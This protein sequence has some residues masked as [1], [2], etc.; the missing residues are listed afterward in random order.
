MERSEW[1]FL[2]PTPLRAATIPRA[3]STRRSS[4]RTWHSISGRSSDDL[5]R[6]SLLHK[7]TLRNQL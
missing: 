3:E 1:A 4:S 6:Q 2:G 7:K 5:F